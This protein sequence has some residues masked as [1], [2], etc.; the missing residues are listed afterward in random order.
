MYTPPAFRENDEAEIAAI[1]RAARL[2]ILI[3]MG[4]E[5]FAT[6]LPLLH[7]PEPKPHGR[8]IGHVARANPHWHNFDPAKA[9]L[10]VFQ[11]NDAY[12]S[13]SWYATKQETGR[14]V[15]TWNYQAVHAYGRLEVIEDAERLYSIVRSLTDRHEAGRA[16]PWQVSDAPED[17]IRAQLKGIVGLVMTIE[18]LI[19]KSKL[20]QNRNE[21][22]RAGAITGLTEEGDAAMA[23]LMR[24]R[25]RQG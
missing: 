25:E 2:P 1:M 8:L 16:P 10:A 18:K 7:D 20:S 17:Y 6:H 9:A 22:D 14:V 4:E 15:P 3:T 11:A 24:A 13:P 19:G 21:A 5:L 12:I 23:A